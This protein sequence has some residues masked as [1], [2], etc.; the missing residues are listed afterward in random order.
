MSNAR[1][2]ANRMLPAG[3]AI[4]S[5]LTLAGCMGPTY[6]TGTPSDQQLLEDVTG[7]LSLQPEQR[8]PINYQPRGDLVRPASTAVLPQ[9]QQSASSGEAWPE[10]P[11]ARLAR[12]RQEATLNQDDNS[13]SSGLTGPRSAPSVANLD[14]HKGVDS[15]SV[16]RA[17]QREEFNRR[18]ALSQAR[19]PNQRRFLSEPP[20]QY[21]Q[22]AA[23]APVGD[24]G[25]DEWRKERAAKQAQ[26][27]VTWRDMIPGL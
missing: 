7:I 16:D 13:Y 20:T 27:K 15:M 9:P 12:V 19:D 17:A 14:R 4:A 24:V 6:G 8:E 18:L 5:A 25:E 26:G 3:L 23:G 1:L 22:P 21:R 11:E 2:T 10:S